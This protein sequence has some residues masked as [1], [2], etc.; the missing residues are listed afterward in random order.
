MDRRRRDR[1]RRR[2]QLALADQPVDQLAAEHGGEDR[3]AHPR[4]VEVVAAQVR[5]PGHHPGLDQR[6]AGD[7][8]RD[9]DGRGQHAA[10]AGQQALRPGVAD[11]GVDDVADGGVDARRAARRGTCRRSRRPGPAASRRGSR[12]PGPRGRTTSSARERGAAR[13][14]RRAARPSGRPCSWHSWVRSYGV[15]LRSLACPSL[16]NRRRRAGRSGTRRRTTSST[17]WSAIGADLE[18]GTLLEAYRR[19]LFPMPSGLRGDPMYWFCPVRRGILPLDGLRVSRSLRRSCREFEIR[20][21]TA[22]DGW[23]PRAPTRRGRRAGS[24]TTSGRRT[25]RLHRLG[26]AHSVETWRD[27]ELVGG[28]YGIAIGGLFAGESMFHRRRDASKVG[29]GRRWSRGSPTST[30]RTGCSTSSG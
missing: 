21:D 15:A 4:V 28:L 13:A 14:A 27:G 11:V 30:P 3:V 7:V 10:Q 26:W 6:Q 1:H 8:R 25:G 18:P 24:T 5:D 16:R 12:G 20:V 23:S 17:T 19:G 29:A 9:G 2:G 22:F